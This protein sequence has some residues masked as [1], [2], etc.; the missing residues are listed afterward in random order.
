MSSQPTGL[1]GPPNGR[2]NVRTFGPETWG[3]LDYFL[4]FADANMRLSPRARR[5]LGGVKSHLMKV[6]RFRRIADQMRPSLNDDHIELH[7]NGVSAL[8][9]AADFALIVE[10]AI[11]E[12][13]A[14]VDS[15]RV[16]IHCLYGRACQ[17]IPES[18]SKLFS[19]IANVTGPLPVEL[20]TAIQEA[21]WFPELLGIRSEL[22]HLGTGECRIDIP[23]GPVRY[24]LQGATPTGPFVTADVIYWIDSRFDLINAFVG[25]VFHRL[26]TDLSKGTDTLCGFVEGRPL[27]RHIKPE[28]PVSWQSGICLS[29]QY[30]FPNGDTR[31]PWQDGC[32]PYQRALANPP[33]PNCEVL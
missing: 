16:V 5:A 3:E 18:T 29:S 32:Q 10:G 23:D 1:D 17:G 21:L 15:T 8:E 31:C 30:L 28:R 24:E 22:T 20:R 13:F 27:M 19:G 7:V 33:G 25:A 2:P 4:K 14:V 12:L 6:N 9:K 11:M 26:G